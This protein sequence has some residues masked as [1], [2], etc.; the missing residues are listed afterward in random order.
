M[1]P[2]QFPYVGFRLFPRDRPD[3]KPARE[4]GVSGSAAGALERGLE[5]IR[6]LHRDQTMSAR[7]VLA[8]RLDAVHA[9]TGAIKTAV[10]AVAERRPYRGDL[11]KSS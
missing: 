5:V 2:D 7:V 6:A 10:G 4:L 8:R 9:I 11:A 1:R 3:R